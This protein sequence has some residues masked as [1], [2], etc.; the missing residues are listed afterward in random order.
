ML[1]LILQVGCCCCCC[2]GPARAAAAAL[3]AAAAA[4]GTSPAA[5]AAAAGAWEGRGLARPNAGTARADGSEPLG[6]PPLLQVL[7]LPCAGSAAGG[8]PC[9]ALSATGRALLERCCC[10]C[11]CTSPAAAAS[12]SAVA[13]SSSSSASCCCRCCCLARF[14]A[15]LPTPCPAGIRLSAPAASGCSAPR[16]CCCRTPSGDMPLPAAATA[17][18]PAA[19]AAAAALP[20]PCWSPAGA[21]QPST[22]PQALGGGARSSGTR[23]RQTN[24]YTLAHSVGK[25]VGVQ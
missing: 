22:A 3:A 21:S 1:L 6:I 24:P 25:V 14:L 23:N 2:A 8:A 16:C 13:R 10:C 12:V 5:T 18:S 11:C 20:P 7:L 17:A 9:L 4:N 15:A 19:A